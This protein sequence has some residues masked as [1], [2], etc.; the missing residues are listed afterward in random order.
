M[1][2]AIFIKSYR[3]DFKWLSGCLRSIQK[4]A[5]GFSEIVIA[6]PDTDSLDHLTAERVV[7]V[8]ES[9]GR[10]YM[11]QQSVKMLADAFT[12]AD[13]IL[14]V[15]SDCLFTAPVTPESFLTD[16]KPNWLHT[17]WANVGDD[18]KRA[19]GEVMRKCVGENPPSEF[20]RRLPQIVPRWALEEFRGFIAKKHGVSLEYYIMNQ[21]GRHFSEFNC[22]G[23]FLWLN[24]HDKINWIN[25]DDGVPPTVVR[26][27]WS[28]GGVTPEIKEERKAI[29]T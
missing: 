28:W 24:H 7:K 14:L 10:G 8:K 13:H 25:T 16:G 22:L 29:L 9:E 26:Q 11:F 12:D 2:T 19:W 23:F 1:T 15:D 18:A 3:N 4:F 20:M 21:P 5:T 27:F 6:I 17:P